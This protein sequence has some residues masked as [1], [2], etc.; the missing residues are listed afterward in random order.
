M[1]DCSSS[2]LPNRASLEKLERQA[3]FITKVGTSRDVNN[4]PIETATNPDTGVTLPTMEAI[5]ADI[6]AQGNAAILGLGWDNQGEFS[7]LPLMSDVND[8]AV[9][10][11]NFWVPTETLPYTATGS[12]PLLPPEAGK[13]VVAVTAELLGIA[14]SLNT[15]NSSVEYVTYAGVLDAVKY[16]YDAVN[17]IIWEVPALNGLGETIVGITGD[18]LQTNI[19]FYTLIGIAAPKVHNM[20][21]LQQAVNSNQLKPTDSVNLKSHS[22]G[23]G[24]DAMWDVVLES[25]VVVD[26]YRVVQSIAAPT[27]ALVLRIT[28]EMSVLSFGAL[29]SLADNSGAL[30]SAFTSGA[31]TLVGVSDGVFDYTSDINV[32]NYNLTLKDLTLNGTGAKTTFSGNIVS[33]GAITGGGVKGTKTVTVADASSLSVDDVVV[34]HNSADFSFSQHRAN[35]Q[36]GEYNRIIGISGNNLTLAFKLQGVSDYPL[37]S[38]VTLYKFNGAEVSFV[39]SKFTSDNTVDYP[40]N[41]NFIK[42]SSL[43]NSHCFGGSTGALNINKCYNLIT[44]G[45]SYINTELAA[46]LQYGVAVSN[47]Q[48][49]ICENGE[50]FGSRHGCTTGGDSQPGAVPNRKIQ[51]NSMTV[52][53][54]FDI[55]AA[56]FHGNTA[57]SYYNNCVIDGSVGLAG[58]NI[59]I[60]NSS[61]N[62]ANSAAIPVQ[63][64]EIVGGKI[65]VKDMIVTMGNGA[66]NTS[67]VAHGSSSISQNIDRNYHIDIDGI[68]C[69]I[70]SSVNKI[71]NMFHNAT[72]PVSHR[73]TMTNLTIRGNDSSLVDIISANTTTAPVVV[74]LTDLHYAMSGSQSYMKI[75]GGNFTGC[76]CTLPPSTSAVTQLEVASSGWFSTIGGTS[77]QLVF[78]HPDYPATPFADVMHQGWAVG[79]APQFSARI[80]SMS[81][82]QM[83]AYI[84]TAD[85][86]ITTGAQRAFQVQAKVTFENIVL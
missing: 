49:I 71:L 31:Q 6:T 1:S 53:N 41:L 47:S 40:L 51:F 73:W 17:Q 7:T 80:Q 43:V 46:S 11:G 13:W 44:S 29:T 16:L 79:N 65:S 32:L 74:S 52:G 82:T 12:S 42:K 33:L 50:A 67:I 35:Y 26:G 20:S 21:T 85:A 38:T 23:N 37:S 10:E 84:S 78:N 18:Q 68:E 15:L 5:T 75:T 62:I 57:D 76:L 36:D 9:F 2:G 70:S 3:E 8:V 22:T 30:L 56:D 69:D 27:L 28:T 45:G 63:L 39:T 54:D 4:L 25:S 64:H 72:L 61:V 77:G 48:N 66:S 34:I 14:R 86:S 81:A 60:R 59:G 83:Q 55:Y 19:T 24:G 58:E